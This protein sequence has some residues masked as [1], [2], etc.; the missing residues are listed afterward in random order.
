MRY[1][2]LLLDA[3]VLGLP[4]QTLNITVNGGVAPYTALI[5]VTQPDG[6]LLVWTQIASISTF[7][8]GPTEASDT[9][10]GV[11]Q[12]GAWQAQVIVNGVSSNQVSWTTVWLPVHVTR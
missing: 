9:Y 5:Y 8:F 11:S 7:T 2:Y 12:I 1:P 6:T 4:A 10:F 3:P